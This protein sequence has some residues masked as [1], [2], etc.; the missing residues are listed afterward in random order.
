M[1]ETNKLIYIIAAKTVGMLGL[2]TVESNLKKKEPFWKRRIKQ[3]KERLRKDAAQL[4]R[5]VRK[6]MELPTI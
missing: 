4:N 5:I 1:E 3:T 2:K 6:E